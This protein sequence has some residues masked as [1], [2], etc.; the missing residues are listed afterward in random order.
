MLAG[1]ALLS[2]VQTL[3]RVSMQGY[4]RALGQQETQHANVQ[5]WIR[6]SG[7]GPPPPSQESDY[8]LVDTPV[9]SSPQAQPSAADRDLTVAPVALNELWADGVA[10]ERAAPPLGAADVAMGGP[11]QKMALSVGAKPRKKHR[12]GQAKMG[13]SR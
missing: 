4:G 6:F 2:G 7:E 3:D 10:T 13:S 1:D 5:G 12:A 8:I 9:R 11:L